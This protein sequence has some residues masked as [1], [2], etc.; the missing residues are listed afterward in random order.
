MFFH[1]FTVADL[2]VVEWASAKD[3]PAVGTLVSQNVL[4]EECAGATGSEF[5]RTEG[6]A[7]RQIV[8]VPTH[9]ARHSHQH[10]HSL[11]LFAQSWWRRGVSSNAIHDKFQIRNSEHD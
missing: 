10:S 2:R 8:L 5:V 3:R 1:E 11:R 9:C 4:T 6:T 7:P